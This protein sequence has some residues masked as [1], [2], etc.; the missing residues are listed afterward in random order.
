[1]LAT[2]TLLFGAVYQLNY[3]T[4]AHLS[5]PTRAFLGAT[6]FDPVEPYI[7]GAFAIGAAIMLTGIKS[8]SQ[9]RA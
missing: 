2:E 1:V 7:A 4:A 9:V 3:M 8:S 6:S 5:K